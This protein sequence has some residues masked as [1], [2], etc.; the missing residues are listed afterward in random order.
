MLPTLTA[1]K[2][3]LPAIAGFLAFF[4][5]LFAVV[6]YALPARRNPLEARL[7]DYTP[8][9]QV[10]LDEIEMQ[11]PFTERFLRPFTSQFARAFARFTPAAALEGTQRRLVLAGVSQRLTVSDFVGIRGL[12][13]VV[14]LG[15]G[16][17]LGVVSGQSAVTFVL[18]LFLFGSIAFLIP[19]LWL[20]Q[21]TSRRR[22]EIITV[23]PDA[24]DLLT[25][26]VEAGL[27]FD[28]AIL[29]VVRKSRNALTI[30][31][32][33]VLYEMQFGVARRDALHAMQERI[34]LDDLSSV[35]SAIIQAEQLGAS[36][37][38]V[39]RV[40]ATEMRV[41]RRQHAERLIRLAPVKMLFPIA[42][43]IF[44]PVFIVVL[45]PAIPGILKTFAPGLSL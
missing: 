5:V 42:F 12:V 19:G 28:Q 14:A 20:R 39:L 3:W 27:G 34:G 29:R 1:V 18:V 37:A 16:A 41:R 44:P 21:L 6:G 26:S 15:L 43:L 35:I 25:I 8:G 22:T 13:T 31:F 9:P 45:G 38:N 11:A 24:I 33:R 4:G 10:T 17:A 36:L 32:G 7:Q 2:D 40:Q 30:E 23:M